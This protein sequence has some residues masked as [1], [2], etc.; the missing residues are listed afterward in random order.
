[1]STGFLKKTPLHDL[2]KKS[3]AAFREYAGWLIPDHYGYAAEETRCV[4]QAAGII[5]VSC[6]AK[7]RV[8][9]KDRAPF[10][11][12][13]VSNDVKKL[14]PDGGAYTAMLN[15]QARVLA[16]FHLFCFQDYLLLDAT[17]SL[18]QKIITTLDKYIIMEDVSLTDVTN[19]YAFLGLEGPAAP[20]LINALSEEN[21][22]ALAPY[23]HKKI[24]L[25]DFETEMFKLSFTGSEGY[26]FLIEARMAEGLWEFLLKQGAAFGLKPFGAAAL[27]TLRIEAGIPWYGLDMDERNLLPEPGLDH[28]VSLDKGCYIGQEMISRLSRFAKVNKKLVGFEMDSDHAPEAGARVTL[29]G[30]NIGY[31]TSSAFSSTLNQWIGLGYV[32]RDYT[33]SGTQVSIESGSKIQARVTSLPFASCR[34]T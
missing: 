19:D 34:K 10:L 28:A 17:A 20:M 12:S 27:N 18:T 29:D 14:T 5:D 32:A 26:Y 31:L 33:S 24:K 25:G 8:G 21:L 4:K 22:N 9:G 30:K 1:M 6:R 15:A 11:H 2:E 7:I 13:M 16:D 3:G 23:A